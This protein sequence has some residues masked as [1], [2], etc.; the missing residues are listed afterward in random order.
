[1]KIAISSKENN[2]SSEIDSRFGRCAFFALYETESKTTEFVKNEAAANEEGAGPAAIQQ[3]AGLEVK[4]IIACDFGIKIK[5]L[6][7]DLNI[8][9]I[10][11]KE[12]KTVEEIIKLLNH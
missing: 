7:S 5:S 12:K 3:L 6:C 8:Q 11:I 1:M 10:I 2:I 9:L 4:K